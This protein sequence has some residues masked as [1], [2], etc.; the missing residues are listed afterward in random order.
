MEQSA[1]Q[2]RPQK[3]KYIENTKVLVSVVFIIIRMNV[4]PDPPSQRP[5]RIMQSQTPSLGRHEQLIQN[6]VIRLKPRFLRRSDVLAR[7]GLGLIFLD[8]LEEPVRF[9]FGAGRVEDCVRKGFPALVHRFQGTAIRASDNLKF[10][11]RRQSMLVWGQPPSV[12]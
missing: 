3:V 1:H 2:P 12:Q 7:R 4:P 11:P 10:Y 6:L 5:P 8:F 9:G